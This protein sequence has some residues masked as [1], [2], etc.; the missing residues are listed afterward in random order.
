MPNNQFLQLGTALLQIF[1]ALAAIWFGGLIYV[2]NISSEIESSFQT[3]ESTYEEIVSIAA[4][5][6]TVIGGLSLTAGV[7]YP[8][9]LLITFS[10]SKFGNKSLNIALVLFVCL[11]SVILVPSLV[12]IDGFFRKRIFEPGLHNL[13]WKKRVEMDNQGIHAAV[14]SGKSSSIV[15]STFVGKIVLWLPRMSIVSILIEVIVV[16]LY[17]NNII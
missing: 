4:F 7:L 1:V 17:L 9:L 10:L 12:L 3:D 16:V 15:S 13:E 5:I 14:D 8:V 6:G 11:F 2:I